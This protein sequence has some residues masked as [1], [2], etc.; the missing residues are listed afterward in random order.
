MRFL[1]SIIFLAATVAA[2]PIT[3]TNTPAT[4]EITTPT[5]SNAL[6]NKDVVANI[7]A[8]ANTNDGP[9]WY[10]PP[11]G[12]NYGP[13]NGGYSYNYN[14]NSGPGFGSSGPPRPREPERSGGALESLGYGIGSIIGTPVGWVAEIVGG[15]GSGLYN[16]LKGSYKMIKG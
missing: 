7:A 13:P 10:G 8:T 6:D 11:N 3:D 9:N 4:A 14:Y 16:G 5:A 1:T 12:G 15:A 2:L